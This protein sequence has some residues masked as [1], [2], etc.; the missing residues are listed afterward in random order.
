[1]AAEFEFNNGYPI[2]VAFLAKKIADENQIYTQV[3][4]RRSSAA[5]RRVLQLQR[6]VLTT[7]TPCRRHH[8]PLFSAAVQHAYRRSLAVILILAAVDDEKGPQLFKVDPAGHFLSFKARALR[9][10][11]A[12]AVAWVAG[13][14]ALGVVLPMAHPSFTHRRFW[15]THP[16]ICAGHGGGRQGGGRDERAGEAVEG[17]VRHRRGGPH[18]RGRQRAGG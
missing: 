6:T 9:V 4:A 8:R 12:G 3:R 1:M 14:G 18:R 16:S 7:R 15:R 13:Q 2:P 5:R 10:T 17:R 11:G